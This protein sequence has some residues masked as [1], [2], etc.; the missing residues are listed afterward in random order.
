MQDI[1]SEL[2]PQQQKAVN[3][4]D[5]PLLILAG[6]GSGKTRALTY[7]AAYLILNKKINPGNILLLTFT[8][9]AAE[10]MK[11]RIKKLLPEN[12]LTGE[13]SL[14]AGT[15]HSFCARILRVE[16]DLLGIPRNFVIY[17]ETDQI[18]AIKLVI[19][20]LDLSPKDFN[21]NSVLTAISEAKNELISELEYPQYART[22]W[23]KVIAQIYLEYQKKLFNS[24]ALDF[25]D[26]L[27]KTVSLFKKF[28]EILGK[29]QNKYQYILV[30]EY[31]DTNHA[32]YILTKT[33]ASLY[34]N[35]TVVG[36]AS[37]S[38]YSWRGANFRNLVNLKNDFPQIKIINLEQN[39]RSTQIILD[40]AHS[41]IKHN[42]SHPILK[43]WTE[44][45]QGEKINLYEAENEIQEADFIVR[46]IQYSKRKLSDF[47]VLY[48]TNAQSRTIEEALIYA[49]IPYNLVGGTKFYQRK[50]IKDLLAYLRLTANKNDE[51]SFQRAEKI[52]K[53]RLKKLLEWEE[54]TKEKRENLTTLEIFDEILNATTYLELY[55][56]SDEEDQARLENI[57][58]LRSVAASFPVLDD[59]LE[60]VS[61][62]EQGEY[63]LGRQKSKEKNVD[64]I[65]L[66]TL[67]SAKGLE[68]PVV[69]I[70]GMEEGIFP[71]AR[72]L[73]DKNQIEEE[74]RLCYVGITRAKEKLFLTYTCRRM[75]FGQFSSNEVSRFI[76]DIPVDLVEKSAGY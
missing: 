36:D 44:N 5:G 26:L 62:V 65:S 70:I 52:G 1:L 71:H 4:G 28:P 11:L 34:Q 66:M 54:K 64:A 23:Q 29:Y 24:S 45:S 51:V 3:Y 59:F 21:P 39:Y 42:Q 49:G 19:K 17:D 8:N 6:A 40:V 61:L 73:M 30:D 67:H 41:I 53:N 9:K 35:L 33:L 18:E 15:F 47:A 27:S 46:Q 37:Q 48:R 14:F 22:P 58:E 7:R 69:F 57:S 38:I 50:E 63:L 56:S 25:D 68:F 12:Q 13:K 72:S 75:F 55:D 60:N 74:R 20:K 2:N 43:L 76:S 32:Q 31:Q 16:G 10:E